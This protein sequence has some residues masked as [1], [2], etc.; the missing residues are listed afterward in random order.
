MMANDT[1]WVADVRRWVRAA[2]RTKQV[3]AAEPATDDTNDVG[4]EAA[5]PSLLAG[6]WVAAPRTDFTD[7]R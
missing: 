6:D 5:H 1:D 3:A 2:A 7:L 4:Y